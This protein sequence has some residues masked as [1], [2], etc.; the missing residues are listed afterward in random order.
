M[1]R[2]RKR[3]L[4]FCEAVTLAHV[5]RPLAL[6]ESL[7]ADRYDI[8]MACASRYHN[9]FKGKPWQ[10]IPLQS[11][12]G[13]QFLRALSRGSPVYDTQTLRQ[14]VKDDLQIIKKIDP[15]VI[16][17]DFRLS[18]SVSARIVGIPY[19]TITNAYWS[20]YYTDGEFPLPVLSMT[21]ILPLALANAVFRLTLPLA[22]MLHCAPLNHVRREKG[23]GS[24][25]ASLQRVYTDADYV[26]FADIPELFPATG[27]PAE[28]R[29]LG[30]ILW[31]PP[32]AKPGWWDYLPTDKP[33]IYL[34]LGSS[35]QAGLLPVVLDALSGLP[36]TVIA[37]TVED[38]RGATPGN[39]YL[40]SYLPG[41]EAARLSRMVI[42]NGGSPTSSQALAA[43]VPVLGIASN[44]DQFLN[45]EALVRAG[46][47]MVMRADRLTGDAIEEAVRNVLFCPE[48]S[49]NAR[50]VL[51]KIKKY[52]ASER[53]ATFMEGLMDRPN[54]SR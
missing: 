53:F 50:V 21:K 1:I 35:G 41:I 14:Y 33:I 8:A 4:F 42:C 13:Q 32:M 46:A 3:V 11:I 34:T 40:A 37:A 49:A 7:D 51:E 31:S 6:A 20:P 23:M 16:V 9:F 39:V 27:L 19:I 36:V 10:F 47:G 17:G 38:Y 25:G 54:E 26:L 30:P 18:L 29:Y 2:N 28:H 15:D 5:A 45:M 52:N 24:L 22:L 12:G 48:F 43:G 44:A